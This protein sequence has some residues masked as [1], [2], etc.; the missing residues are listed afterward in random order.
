M[1]SKRMGFG[2]A[3][4]NHFHDEFVDAQSNYICGGMIYHKYCTNMDGFRNGSACVQK[5]YWY[6]ERFYRTPIQ[7]QLLK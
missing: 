1:S 7:I 3:I 2:K 5:D 4:D 6:Y